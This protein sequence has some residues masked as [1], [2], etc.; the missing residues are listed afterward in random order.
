MHFLNPAAL[1]GLLAVAIP[2]AIHLLHRGRSRPV[3]FSNLEL[4]RSLHQSRMRRLQVRQWL[5]LLLRALAVLC[6]VLAFA[7][8]ALRRGGPGLLGGSS[9]V[10]AALLLDR[11]YSTRYEVAG[12]RVYDRLEGTAAALLDLFGD[13]DELIA[14]PFD[15]APGLPL[16]RPGRDEVD[17]LA[18]STEGTDVGAALRRARDLLG[19]TPPH[20]HREVYLLGDLTRRGWPA[21]TPARAPGDTGHADGWLPGAQ[22]YLLPPDATVP[23]NVAVAGLEVDA[24]LQS[25]GQRLDLRARIANY[26]ERAARVG[27]SLFVDG[28]RVQR[29]EVAVPPRSEGAVDLSLAPRRVGRLTGYVEIDADGLP[30]DDR[31]HF[32]LHVPERIR[33]LALG[34]DPADA[35]FVRTALA[36]A[37]AADP[38]LEVR[39][40]LLADL[41]ADALDSADV[42]FLCNL[43]RLDRAHTRLVHDF[44]ERG[45]GLVLFPGRTADLSYYNR[46][47]LPGLL[48]A[49]LVEVTGA[50]GAEAP[51]SG[52]VDP[53]GSR[54]PL[55]TGLAGAAG[56]PVR[57]LFRL[58]PTRP[59]ANLLQTADRRP[60][61]VEGWVRPGRV[62]LFAL[63]LDLDWSDLPLD[64]RF[65]PL[66]H[67]LARHA[68]LPPDHGRSYTVGEPV[69][70]HVPGAAP[71]DG[72]QAEAPSGRRRYLE[73]RHVDG[74]LYW[75]I[76]AIDEPGIWRLRRGDEVVDLFAVH[77]D[78]RE[79]DLS[80][81]DAATAE[82]LFAPGQVHWLTEGDGLVEEVRRSRYGRELW[83]ELLLV[84]VAL[85]LLELWLAR[86]PDASDEPD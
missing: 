76:D 67:R 69:R 46:Q 28:Q 75:A 86:A 82:R 23:A 78:G 9:R 60:V 48:P 32:V 72:L 44:V 79:S 77:V 50:P 70:R 51:A 29:R 19:E 71:G 20:L 66:V 62:V 30:L 11:S 8:P 74:R 59:L 7:R 57:A 16:H 49:T 17:E 43:P 3:P 80:R 12:R 4:L 5:I 39:T 26:G 55:L 65:A 27:A 85:L 31:R 18:P 34:P 81:I 2:L 63:P 37:A 53:A 10:S 36:A 61:A 33:S 45:G 25:R 58:V 13:D 35:Y 54:H 64:G 42:L 21:P 52:R 41:T 73:P 22:V 1:L 40:G 14:I 24:W 47:L 68:I 84:A 83:R 56:P 38:A 15:R 6:L